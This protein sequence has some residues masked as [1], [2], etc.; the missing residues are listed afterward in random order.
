MTRS[1][2]P[3]PAPAPQDA[4]LLARLQALEAGMYRTPEVSRGEIR[5]LLAE[6]QRTKDLHA[7]AHAHLLLAGCA[8]YTGQLPEVLSTLST[9]LTLAVQVQDRPLE[10]RVL[11]GLGLGYDRTGQY[12][13]ALEAYLQS[14]RITQEIGDRTGSFRAL[15]NL[16]SLYSDTGNLTQALAF[17]EQA[18]QIAEALRE[19]VMLASSMTHLLLIHD[20]L[21]HPDD[22][23]A[24]A[25]EHLN[26]IQE[27]GPPR[28]TSTAQECVASA[29]LARG[30]APEAL[31]VALVNLDAARARQDHEGTCRLATAGARA[32]LALNRPDEAEPLLH[33]SLTL[34][35]EVGSR[36]VEIRALE[37][38]AALHELRGEH[39]QALTVAR[40]HFVLERQLHAHE[41]DA[42]SHLL[43]AEIRLELLNREAEIERLRN[44][45]LA[46]ANQQLQETQQVLLHR[47]THDPLTGVSNRAH[48]HQV[49][50]DT[51]S[52]LSDGELAALIFIDLDGFKRVNDTLGHPAGDN[53]LQQV[54]R[55]LQGAVRSSD[56]V[57]RMGGDEFTVLLRRV[58]VRQD[59][60]LVAQ[61]LADALAEPFT[62][63]GQNVNLT[64]SVGCA[65]APD[66]GRDAEALQQHA[67]MAMY[68]VK[69][70]GGNRVLHFESGMGE[71]GEQELL[72][73]DLRLALDRGE[74]LLHY[75]GRYALRGPALVG[76]EALIR[77]Q[78]PQ[79]GL[80]PPGV[81]I[82]V[83][84]DT[85][86]ILQIG[87]W[88]LREACTQAV[89]WDFARRGLSM[90]VNVS[91]LQFELPHFV[92][93]VCAALSASGLP[94]QHLI[95]EITESLVMRDLERAQSH[96]HALKALG[97]QIAMDDF[98]T[99]YSSLSV[100][101][102]LPFD[103]LKID[104]SFTRHLSGERRGRVA[105]LMTAMI[106]LAQ[107]LD[108]TV[109][110]EGVEE[111]TQKDLLTELGCDHVQGFLLAR[112]VPSAQAGA[113]IANASPDPS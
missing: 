11:N 7:E 40:Q 28:W 22:V 77:W 62:L 9:C 96:I 68:R 23:L 4:T 6:A 41:V 100:L 52:S 5:T 39:Q 16:A 79:R 91:P 93:T 102:S 49:T 54:A 101:E 25:E 70:S 105:A 69:R 46:R 24:L 75:Q 81:F 108:M 92:D 76:F 80:I 71:P 53:L 66:D 32:L 110:V 88:V 51:L 57:G 10:A 18:L 94:A 106:H 19:P 90:S 82:P 111:H 113:L 97:V 8:L 48:F 37:S 1:V 50:H 2:L 47:A 14:L 89:T 33:E 65:V 45:E 107:T 27:V 20:R 42:R 63:G 59:V 72:E 74:L 43:T 85:R 36:P 109:T 38:L 61:K 98:G 44:V 55:R 83:A 31:S 56:L 103:Q 12:S 34:S 3:D 17:H 58:T 60:T 26:L 13:R 84:E 104:R 86:V 95:L 73:R 64:A 30:R 112:P 15:N 87:E 99:G 21:G 29:L 35:R 78:H 67:D